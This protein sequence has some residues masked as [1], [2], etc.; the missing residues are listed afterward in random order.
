V[1]KEKQV[2]VKETVTQK[3]E[4]EDTSSL[5]VLARHKNGLKPVS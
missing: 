3:R 5:F 1:K 2:E 4:S